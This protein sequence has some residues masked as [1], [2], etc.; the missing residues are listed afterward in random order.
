MTPG[1]VSGFGANHGKNIG[2]YA[3][4]T[5]AE[6]Q[7]L[8][9]H[10]QRKPKDSAQWV[11]PST[12]M[13]RVYEE[14]RKFGEYWMLWADLDTAPPPV[15]R[16]KAVIEGLGSDYEIYASRSA[17]P[18]VPKCRILIPLAAGLDRKSVV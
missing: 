5:Y 15:E 16:V 6:I 17:T 7:G 12:L 13:S 18:E 10:P 3:S 11:I 9:D 14:Q 8:V 1:M 2:C 4:V